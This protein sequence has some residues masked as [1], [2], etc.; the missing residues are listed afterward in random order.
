MLDSCAA[1]P[2]EAWVW[3]RGGG[4][5]AR[6]RLGFEGGQAI[7]LDGVALDPVQLIEEL[8]RRGGELA[9]GRG[10]H[11]G[12]T[13]LGIKGRIAF[14]APAAEILLAAHRE[15]EKLVL[16]EDQRFWKDHL[17]EVY[18]RRLHQ[19][20]L[21]DPCMRDIEAFMASSQSV[22]EGQVHVQLCAGQV[23]VTGVES[24]YS[25]LAASDAAYGERAAAG[26][27]PRAGVCLGRI[28]AEPARLARLAREH[29]AQAPAGAAR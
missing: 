25:L 3:T 8:N 17:G 13:V 15:L 20:L 2:D 27:D 16:T 26:A 28:L 18:G 6:L 9:V 7:A 21:H 23:I 12:D 22:V 14:E 4:G 11:L 5:Q 24:A 19:G 29:A 10:Y 1:L